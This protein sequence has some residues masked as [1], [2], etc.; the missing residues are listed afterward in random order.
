MLLHGLCGHAG[1]WSDTAAWLSVSHRV[2]I[3]EQRGHGRSERDPA[4]VSRTAFVDDAV[5]WVQQLSLSPAV[6][7]GHS[8]GGHTAF[9]LA[10]R[11]PDLVHG[12]VVV[13]ATPQANPDAPGCVRAW[14]E[15]W[16]APFKSHEQ[17]IAFFGGDTPRAQA[18]V[19]GLQK[20]DDGLWPSFEIPAMTAALEEVAGC[21]YWDEWASI[22]CPVLVVRAQAN[23]L[24]T[25]TQRMLKLVPGARLVEIPNSGHDVHLDQ[26]ERWR[27]ALETFLFG[28]LRRE[29]H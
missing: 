6:F 16:P 8:L 11:H 29:Q 28:D 13:E 21:S 17:A 3:P 18:W 22:R 26:A 9:L 5:M 4:D 10:A 2:V 19:S 24:A 15:A 25:D 20:H 1:E 12:L 23:A 27:E 7:V 14:L